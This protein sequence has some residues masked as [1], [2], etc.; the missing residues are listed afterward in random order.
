[1]TWLVPPGGVPNSILLTI[2][3]PIVLGALANHCA[4]PQQAQGQLGDVLRN[5]AQQAQQQS[6]QAGGL[7]GKILSQVEA[8]RQ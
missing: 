2:L 6:P 1:M 4:Q 5:E 7:L 8:P 3:A